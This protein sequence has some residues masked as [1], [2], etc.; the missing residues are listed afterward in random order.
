M[1]WIK[2]ITEIFDMNVYN[3]TLSKKELNDVLVKDKWKKAKS[4]G[5]A[6]VSD[7]DLKSL[8]SIKME[9]DNNI[10]RSHYLDKRLNDV[11]PLLKYFTCDKISESPSFIS[12]NYSIRK[13]E[14]EIDLSFKKVKDNYLLRYESKVNNIVLPEF[15]I[16]KCFDKLEFKSVIKE[17]NSKMIEF[18]N[19]T[20]QKLSKRIF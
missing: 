1:K 6:D 7:I 15:S 4:I 8:D 18:E 9:L 19:Y 12:I 5:K 3:T 20:E 14:I 2:R 16:Y 11:L 17:V 10:S 13:E